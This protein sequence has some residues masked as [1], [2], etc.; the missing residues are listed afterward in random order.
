MNGVYEAIVSS[1]REEGR[2]YHPDPTKAVEELIGDLTIL[3]AFLDA[4]PRSFS[5]REEP[6]WAW[7]ESQERELVSDEQELSL[8]ARDRLRVLEGYFTD[9]FSEKDPTEIEIW[10]LLRLPVRLECSEWGEQHYRPYTIS[11]AVSEMRQSTGFR[12][13]TE[14]VRLRGHKLDHALYDV[15]LENGEVDVDV[16]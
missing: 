10:T 4:Y 14:Y 9:A 7:D 1:I 11:E 13:G 3:K 6:K 15:L 2:Q 8:F 12:Y 16:R 5:Y